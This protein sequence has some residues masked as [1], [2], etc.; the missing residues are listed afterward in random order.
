MILTAYINGLEATLKQSR[1]R[2]KKGDVSVRLS[3]IFW[4]VFI[5]FVGFVSSL[6]AYPTNAGAEGFKPEVQSD[7]SL[8]L[9]LT[10]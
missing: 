4:M 5:T 2:I 10:L 7:M 3:R 9:I 6:R 8:Q 1:D